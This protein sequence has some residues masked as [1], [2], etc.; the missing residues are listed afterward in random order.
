MTEQATRLAFTDL[1]DVT[2]SDIRF[3][4]D[5][6]TLL[7]EVSDSLEIVGWAIHRKHKITRI[8]LTSKNESLATAKLDIFRPL[9]S[10]HFTGF[11]NSD[12]A[13]FRL[14]SPVLPTGKF[15][16]SIDLEN[17]ETI[18]IAEFELAKYDRPKLLFMHIPKAAGSTVN[19]FFSNHFS[20]NQ[21]AIHIESNKQWHAS[22]DDLKKLSFLS[23]H[24]SWHT[25]EKRLD[26]GDYFKVTVVRNPYEQLCS[27]L[28]WIK[29]LA[30]PSE[31]QRFKQHP[32]YIQEF[33]LKLGSVNFEDV[34]MLTDL[35]SS[36]EETEKQLVDNCQTRY[37][38]QI[39]RGRSVC[40][41]DAEMA[42]RTSS[43]F[44]HIGT[45]DQISDFLRVVARKMQWP[46]TSIEIRDNVSQ[47][48][49]GLNIA[50][51]DTKAALTPLVRY[52]MMLFD[53]IKNSSS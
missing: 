45:T 53:Y 17:G 16:L 4:L 39:P 52:D 47:S 18:P 14:T 19:T 50:N 44:D 29:R 24:V 43:K 37:F 35:L 3:K 28:A 15:F 48:Y 22:P 9:V 31:I 34:E 30:L 7:N 1:L 46:E 41:E 42:K 11:C 5:N 38:T 20:P 6:S 23:G 12:S 51:E 40:S 49:Y 36:L 32:Q 33:A 26:M 21:F 2:K 27:H 25:L 13:G 10:Q 8:S